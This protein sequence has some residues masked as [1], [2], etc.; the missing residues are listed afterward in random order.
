ME[1][2]R[3]IIV[4]IYPTQVYLDWLIEINIRLLEDIKANED[5]SV[6]QLGRDATAYMLDQSD[7]SMDHLLELNFPFIF[8]HELSIRC[9]V[10]HLWPKNRSYGEF[11]RWFNIKI[12]N[13]VFCV[14]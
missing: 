12:S 4:I 14:E 5:L 9:P 2:I 1:S 11:L 13:D 10:I 8:Q 6:E 3:K 7:Q